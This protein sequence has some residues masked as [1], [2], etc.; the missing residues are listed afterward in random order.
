MPIKS[1]PCGCVEETLRAGSFRRGEKS[2]NGVW[3]TVSMKKRLWW[4]TEPFPVLMEPPSA[5][6]CA[7]WFVC[8]RLIKAI[9]SSPQREIAIK[10]DELN[11]NY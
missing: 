1:F 11:F 2:L 3:Q 4:A 8:S 6:G 7:P 5:I 9:S 10:L